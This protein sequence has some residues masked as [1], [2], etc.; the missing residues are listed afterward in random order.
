[1]Y[2]YE[3]NGWKFLDI[4]T[5]Y[6]WEKNACEDVIDLFLFLL[7]LLHKI[8]LYTKEPWWSWERGNFI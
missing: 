1:M 3:V 6:F 2:T 8:I 5:K 7:L 4:L